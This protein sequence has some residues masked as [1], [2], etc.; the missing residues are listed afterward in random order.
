MEGILQQTIQRSWRNPSVRSLLSS[1]NNDEYWLYFS[2][3]V[4]ENNLKIVQDHNLEADLGL[5]T[6]TL[7]MNKYADLTNTEFVK[8]L[9]GYNVSMR[10]QRVQDR[11]EFVRHSNI[12]LPDS[13]G[14]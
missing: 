1:I 11:H 9:N 8:M 5:H 12:A 13:V 2:R 14:A 6:Y 10:G 3:E 7:G 4:W